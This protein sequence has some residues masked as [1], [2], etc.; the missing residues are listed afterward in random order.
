MSLEDDNEKQ[1]T[2]DY[3]KEINILCTV[4][5]LIYCK[6]IAI[7]QL[8][9]RHHSLINMRKGKAVSKKKIIDQSKSVIW[10]TNIL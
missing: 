7:K 10:S 1:T 3:C 2:S 9:H 8:M 5:K 4:M 6:E